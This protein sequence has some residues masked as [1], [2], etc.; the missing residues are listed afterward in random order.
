LVT[1]SDHRDR[2]QRARRMTLKFV[3]EAV[4]KGQG[5]TAERFAPRLN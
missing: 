2:L 5:I 1:E 3:I 4:L